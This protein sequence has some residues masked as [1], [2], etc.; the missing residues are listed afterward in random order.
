MADE[1]AML[2]REIKLLQDTMKAATQ[3]FDAGTEVVASLAAERK[4]L[5]YIVEWAE[6]LVTSH[7]DRRVATDRL[8][9]L[10]RDYR[11]AYPEPRP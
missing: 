7:K 11:A 9:Q 3:A 2:R 1:E 6:Y 5:R 8:K 10:I 4:S